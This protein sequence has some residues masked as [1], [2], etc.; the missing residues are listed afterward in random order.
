M[1]LSLRALRDALEP[2]LE[3][4]P[5]GEL[6]GPFH[7]AAEIAGVVGAIADRRLVGHL[8]G[9][10]EVPPPDRFG[11]RPELARGTVDEALEE[12]GGLRPPGAAIGVDRHG[13]GVDA[14][15]PHMDQGRAVDPGHHGGAEIGDVGSELRQIGAEVREDVEAHREEAPVGRKRDL[16]GGEIVAPLRIAGEVVHAVGDPLDRAAEAARGFGRERVFAVHEALGAEAAADVRRDHPDLRRVDLQHL[17]RERV[18]QAVDALAR[19]RQGEA[20]GRG[21][22]GRDDAAGFHE[23]GDQ[24]VVLDRDRGA[25][26][27][28]GEGLL[29]GG[30]VAEARIEGDV[31]RG[32]APD[33]RRA[34]PDRPAQVDDRRQHLVVDADR[35][36]AVPCR[37]DV[38]GD[39]EGD[40]VA[41]VRARCRGRAPG[42]APDAPGCRR[43]SAPA[44]GRERRRD[45][46]RRAP[47][48]PA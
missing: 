7:V 2:L 31:V 19:D 41:D 21:V 35:L 43:R 46:R 22:I 34:V 18:A 10:D 25:A 45:A 32:F 12:V 15:D 4:R 28:L 17:V 9:L 26:G 36:D 3:A 37:R 6:H 5:I 14:A 47:S 24:P 16:A 8:P 42:C 20:L 44:P 30:F 39:D 27:R 29:D 48:A 11:L 13:V 40:G 38:V 23:V 33:R 1:P